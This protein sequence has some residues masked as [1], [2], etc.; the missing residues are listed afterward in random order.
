MKKVMN[1]SLLSLLTK[2]SLRAGF[3]S[4]ATLHP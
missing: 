4:M 2:D 3:V 1:D